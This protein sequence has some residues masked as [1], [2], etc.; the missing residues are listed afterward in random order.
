MTRRSARKAAMVVA[1]GCATFAFA[2]VASARITR[3]EITQIESPAFGGASFGAVGAYEGPDLLDEV[4]ERAPL[5]A[6]QRMAE[7][8]AEPA[9]VG[10]Q[11]RVVIVVQ[12]HNARD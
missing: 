11:G 7:Q 3:I 1:L 5:L 12:F 9:D 4:E 10:A 2:R 6:H 8:R